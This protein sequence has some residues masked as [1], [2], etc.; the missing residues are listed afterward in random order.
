[1]NM[2][3]QTEDDFPFVSVDKHRLDAELEVQ[4]RY[5]M[6]Y[7]LLLADAEED[8]ELAV[9][10]RKTVDAEL[11]REVRLNPDRFGIVKV[12][13]KAVEVA[14]LLDPRYKEAHR[15]EVEAQH[16]LTVLKNAIKALDHRKS[17][18]ENLV[19][20]HF[21][22]YFARPKVPA[23]DREVLQESLTRDVRR[24]GQVPYQRED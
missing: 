7:A 13:E 21:A 3:R 8:Y 6:R 19:Q 5:V 9:Q 10:G 22:G 11:D 12:T 1:M 17:V 2:A 16:A 23:Q 20:L 14:V 15:K 24:R 4:A 18:V